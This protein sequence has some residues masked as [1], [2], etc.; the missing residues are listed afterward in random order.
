[1]TFSCDPWSLATSVLET[2]FVAWLSL[3]LDQPAFVSALACAQRIRPWLARP[4]PRGHASSRKLLVPSVLRTQNTCWQTVFALQLTCGHRQVFGRNERKSDSSW[5][6][7]MRAPFL[8]SSTTYHFYQS[9][10]LWW[11][12]KEPGRKQAYP[13]C[14]DASLS[15]HTRSGVPCTS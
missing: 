2:G 9:L 7:G 14:A 11:R 13:W 12:R 15:C 6:A 3:V 1:M 8:F 10:L 5:M 4:P